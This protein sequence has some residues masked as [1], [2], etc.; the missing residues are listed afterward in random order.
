MAGKRV[1]VGGVRSRGRRGWKQ[2]KSGE[3]PE[4]VRRSCRINQPSHIQVLSESPTWYNLRAAQN[5]Q[6]IPQKLRLANF[7][8]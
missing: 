1:R 6:P 5:S 8:L 3:V 2:D 7:I 4:G